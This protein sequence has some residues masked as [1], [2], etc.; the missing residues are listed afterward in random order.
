MSMRSHLSIVALGILAACSSSPPPSINIGTSGTEGFREGQPFF[1]KSLQE[2]VT[3]FYGPSVVPERIRREDGSV[4]TYA[5]LKDAELAARRVRYGSMSERLAQRIDGAAPNTIFHVAIYFEPHV[6]WDTLRPRLAMAE[7][8]SRLAAQDE[9]TNQIAT[10]AQIIKASVEAH[11]VS[12]HSVGRSMP[13]IFAEATAS[14][15]RALKNDPTISTIRLNSGGGLQRRDSPLTGPPNSTSYVQTDAFQNTHGYYASGQNVGMIDSSAHCGLFSGH[16]AFAHLGSVNYEAPPQS[17]NNDGDCHNICDGLYPGTG[18]TM[19]VNN[20]CTD[21]HASQV[22]SVLASSTNNPYSAAQMNLFMGNG[23]FQL[24]NSGSPPPNPAPPSYPTEACT[25]EAITNTYAWLHSMNV[26]TINES[27]GCEGIIEEGETD[28][29]DGITQ[30]WYAATYGM[31]IMKAVN[32]QTIPNAVSCPDDWNT[33]C[34]GGTINGTNH[35]F[36]YSAWVNPSDDSGPTDREEPDIVSLGWGAGTGNVGVDVLSMNATNLWALASVAGTSFSAPA[37]TSQ[38]A[39]LKDMCGG[40]GLGGTMDEKEVRAI[41]KTAAYGINADDDSYSTQPSGSDWR[42]GAGIAQGPQLLDFCGVPGGAGNTT[43]KTLNTQN[44]TGG[45]AWR[46]PGG[47]PKSPPP[48]SYFKGQQI[49]QVTLQANEYFRATLSWDGCTIPSGSP[50]HV[51]TDLDLAL[52]Q[53][54]TNAL[55]GV[56]ASFLDNNEGFQVQVPA[57][58]TYT[59]FLVWANGTYGCGGFPT[60]TYGYSHVHGMNFHNPPTGE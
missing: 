46:R 36:L 5:Q 51:A 50:A 8:T 20:Q 57:A 19:C 17:C 33:L 37:I 53:N 15:L 6:Q 48:G 45:S 34:V 16:Q 29:G 32:D 1:S 13:V 59:V 55:I 47:Y 21:I 7:H 23:G 4:V 60:I 12:V 2:T 31:T 39:L 11:G 28:A 40:Q 49:T 3:P 58:G 25:P 52:I 30:D 26:T 27:F 56:S 24:P 44:L 54:G 18:N 42:D 41:M 43:F 35:T 38:V 14:Q 10:D 22:A 9:L